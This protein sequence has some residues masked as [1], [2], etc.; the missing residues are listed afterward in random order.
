MTVDDLSDK[1]ILDVRIQQ[2]FIQWHIKGT[3]NIPLEQIEQRVHELPRKSAPL[4]LFGNV[5]TLLEAK[6]LLLKKGYQVEGELIESKDMHQFL[7]DSNLIDTGEESKVLWQPASV[8]KEFINICSKPL[9]NSKGLDI[10]CGA[11]S[12]ERRVGKEC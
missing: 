10:A 2:E 11:R 5:E 9:I 7:K 4:T 3:S 8:V 1:T 12:E 6:A